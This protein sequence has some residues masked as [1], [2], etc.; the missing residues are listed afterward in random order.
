M[1]LTA[2]ICFSSAIMHTFLVKQM[3]HLALRFQAGSV[4]ENLFH[5]LGE[6]EVVFGFWAGIFLIWI[7]F[8][9]GDYSA[10]SYLEKQNFT[11][12]A[13]VFVIMAVCST[14]P[15]LNLA[16][17]S[18]ETLSRL[19]PLGGGLPFFLTTLIVGPILG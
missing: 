3:Q 17:N 15:I 14:K 1:E 2:T 9:G 12:P 5:L 7:T 4:A 13:F 16:Q 8:G 18:I 19:L 6:V 11:E 10:A